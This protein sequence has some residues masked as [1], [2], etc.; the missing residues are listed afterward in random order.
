MSYN[1]QIFEK[2]KK[3]ISRRRQTAEEEAKQRRDELITACPEIEEIEQ[4]IAKAGLEA[5]RAISMGANA[6]EYIGKLAKKNLEQQQQRKDLLINL[7]VDEDY[8]EVKYF[9]PICEDRGIVDGK[10]CDCFKSLLK[11]YAYDELCKCSPVKLS[12]FNGFRLDFYPDQ[13]DSMTGISPRSRMEEVLNYCRSWADDFDREAPSIIMYGATGLGKTHLSLAMAKSALDKGYGVV[14]GSTQS[15]LSK[16]EREKF[17]RSEDSGATEKLLLECDLLILDDLGAE[18]STSFT[19][20]ALYNIINTRMMTGLPVIINTNLSFEEL[21][22]R[23][24]QRISSRIIGE[25]TPIEFLG[26]D[27][28]QLKSM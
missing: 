26:R 28:R 22:Q 18:F 10:R 12:S 27:I 2:A 1:K 11:K 14:Y 7:G 16:L 6:Q 23:Y 19:T 15:L 3:E 9:C 8:L 13:P 20:S 25:Y 21:E 4:E 24:T 17:G 5:I